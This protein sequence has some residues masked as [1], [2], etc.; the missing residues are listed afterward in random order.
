MPEVA[1][2]AT[3]PGVQFVI[4]V[5]AGVVVLIVGVVIDRSRGSSGAARAHSQEVN[6]IEIEREFLSNTVLGE[7][8]VLSAKERGAFVEKIRFEVGGD[9]VQAAGQALD[10]QDAG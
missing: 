5:L 7:G 2:R 4:F 10:L 6:V 9:R 8:H 3:S 1:L